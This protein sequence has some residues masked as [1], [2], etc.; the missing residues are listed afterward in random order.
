MSK[1]KQSPPSNYGLC[2]DDR[3]HRVEDFYQSDECW[4]CGLPLQS[5]WAWYTEGIASKFDEEDDSAAA[6]SGF[7]KALDVPRPDGGSVER[8]FG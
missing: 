2:L 8:F 5:Y 6:S 1:Q 4:A 7:V 3:E